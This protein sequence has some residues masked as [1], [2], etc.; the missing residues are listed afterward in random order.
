MCGVCVCVYVGVCGVCVY[1]GVCV[2]VWCG[3]CV[4]MWVCVCVCVCVY[5]CLCLQY[6]IN[7]VCGPHFHNYVGVFQLANCE[8]TTGVR[9]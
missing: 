8:M 4:C 6:C 2:C 1:V 9:R 7:V 3:V 5:V